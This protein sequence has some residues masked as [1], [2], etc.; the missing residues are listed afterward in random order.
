MDG[1]IVRDETGKAIRLPGKFKD[2]KGIGWYVDEYNMAQISFNLLDT[3]VT[4]VHEAFEAVK[5]EAEK[6]DIA[7][8]GSEIV[9]LIPLQDILKASDYYMEKENLFIT[10]GFRWKY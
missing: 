4:S 3:D 8:V 5:E 2:V 9:G 10:S 7:V 1:E 6:L